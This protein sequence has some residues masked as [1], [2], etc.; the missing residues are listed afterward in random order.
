MIDRPDIDS[1]LAGELGGWLS[2]QAIVRDEAREKSNSRIIIAAFI[3]LPLL[4]LLWGIG[5]LGPMFSI[6]ISFSIIIG[7]AMWCWM[8]RIA[9]VKE[10]KQ[11]INT[12]LAKALGLSF[13]GELETS[14]GFERAGAYS[15]LPSHDRSRL[16]DLWSGNVAGR[17]FALHEAKLEE[18]RGSGKNRRWVTVFRGI[19]MTIACPDLA[20]ATTLIERA[21][22]HRKFLGLGRTKDSI[23]LEG[24]HLDLVDM[25]HPEFEDHFKVWSNDQVE[26][27]VLIDPIYVERLTKLELAFGGKNVRA[28]FHAGELLI[29]LE[30]DNMFES[31]NMDASRDRELIEKTVDHFMALVELAETLSPE[32]RRR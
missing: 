25:V 8:P 9:A 1:L 20:R 14:E 30:A 3:V 15:M 22:K 21:G 12:A 32:N 19:I 23:K 13:E 28:L 16:E 2:K 27:R 18:R 6:F 4:G 31:G 26:A 24:A 29:V 7:A 11:G 17:S 5:L 10:T